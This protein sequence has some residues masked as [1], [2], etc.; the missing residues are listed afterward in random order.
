MK[1]FLTACA[2]VTLMAASVSAAPQQS[3]CAYSPRQTLIRDAKDAIQ[4]AKLIE[5]GVVFDE[6]PRCGGSLMQLAV[7]RGNT[8]VLVAL[9][10]QDLK[11]ASQI[12]SLD[13]FPIPGAP[14]KVPL[15]LFAAYYAPNENVMILLQKALQQSN[16]NLAVTDELGRNVLWYMDKN[17]VLRK[18]DL[19]D[20]LNSELLTSLTMSTQDLLLNTALGGG[21]A[22]LNAGALTGQSTGSG[23]PMVGQLTT[24]TTTATPAPQASQKEIVEPTK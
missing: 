9:L 20:T 12:V 11:R 22:P 3:E 10:N 19:Y 15:W 4:I 16:Q 18:T 23:Q 5:Q 7:R 17:P 1:K 6:T 2:L 21:H 8:D 14:K 24:P 13:E